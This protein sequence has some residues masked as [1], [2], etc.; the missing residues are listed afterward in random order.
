MP[1]FLAFA[2][3]DAAPSDRAALK[4]NLD[5]S[6]SF[7]LVIFTLSFSG[8]LKLQKGAEAPPRT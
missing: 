3:L 5:Q 6:A 1:P 7:D 8:N 2:L 4:G